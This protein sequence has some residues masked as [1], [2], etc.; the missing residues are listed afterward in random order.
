[1]AE[2]IFKYK[3]IDTLIQC[4]IQDKFKD[5]CQKFCIKSQNNINNL[6]FI[7]GGEILNLDLEFNQVANQIDTN[8]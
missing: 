7:Y 6:I 1:M 4:Q 8:R 5:I 2:I 3:G